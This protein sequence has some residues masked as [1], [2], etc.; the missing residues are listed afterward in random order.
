MGNAEIR[1][2]ACGRLGR[3]PIPTP[4][5]TGSGSEG[6]CIQ[7]SGSSEPPLRLRATIKEKLQKSNHVVGLQGTREVTFLRG[8]ATQ[9]H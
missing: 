5:L 4:V 1:L 6:S 3:S 9:G 7:V 2:R 8:L